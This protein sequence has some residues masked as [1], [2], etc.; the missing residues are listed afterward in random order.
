MKELIYVGA[1]LLAG[2]L[3]GYF[4]GCTLQKRRDDKENEAK[5]KE[6]YETFE[7]MQKEIDE[8]KSHIE[9][10]DISSLDGEE[11]A[12]II[13]SRIRPL[14]ASRTDEKDYRHN[15]TAYSEN[16]VTEDPMMIM[17]QVSSITEPEERELECLHPLD[18]DEDEKETDRYLDGLRDSEEHALKRQEKPRIIKASDFGND[19]T[20]EQK[21]LYY[22]QDNDILLN[23]DEEEIFDG[24]KLS[25]TNW[26][27]GDCL[28]KFDFRTNDEDVIYV[29]NYRLGFDYEIIKVRDAYTPAE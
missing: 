7:K 28:D 17:R 21:T 9:D 20:L 23:E 26:V 14:E 1:G 3:A 12:N 27:V 24:D 19:G 16:G 11:S 22:Y 2:S 6:Y 18:S 13:E 4:A 15:Y 29:R 25:D 8:L 5:F 10:S